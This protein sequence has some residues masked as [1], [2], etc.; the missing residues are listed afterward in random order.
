MENGAGSGEALYLYGMKETCIDH[1]EKRI[2]IMK[3]RMLTMTAAFA[4]CFL[5]CTSCSHSLHY[6]QAHP[7]TYDDFASRQ[8]L[9]GKRMELDS[10]IMRPLDIQ[11]AD[12]LLW[13]IE[14]GRERSVYVVDLATGST[15]CG[16]LQSGQGPDDVVQPVFMQ[17]ASD[18][19]YLFDAATS[20]VLRYGRADFLSQLSPSPSA[21]VRM[22][23]SVFVRAEQWGGRI[24]GCTHRPGSQLA[25]YDASDGTLQDRLI[26]YPECDQ[27]YSDA[28]KVEAFYMNFTVGDNGTLGLCYS[29]TDLLEFYRTDGTLL[30]RLHGPE[31]FLAHFKEHRN[32]EVVTSSPD[33]ELSRDAYFCPRAVGDRLWVLFD[34]DFVNAPDNDF[35][36]SWLMTFTWEGVPDALY[37]LDDPL[38]SFAVDAEHR[39]VYGISVRPEFHVVEYDY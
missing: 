3:K 9:Q 1:L 6:E 32:G 25:V 19:L 36:C 31:G 29:M 18:S 14:Y 39:K 10:L 37:R 12:S 15:R 7:F 24:Y 34:G 4:A 22:S 26:G 5:L 13:L 23:P 8:T 27:E 38:I 33:K 35:S 11:V 20:R 17:S 30:R 28:E 2:G 16:R 21:S